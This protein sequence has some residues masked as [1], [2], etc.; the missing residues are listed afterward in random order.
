VPKF[1][2]YM[3]R[4]DLISLTLKSRMGQAEFGSFVDIMSEPS[5]VDTR[6]RQDQERFAQA[7]LSRGIINISYIFNEDLLAPDREIPWR[8][9]I[10]LS[11]MRKDLKMIPVYG[12]M[13]RQDPQQLRKN[14]LWDA[15]RPIRHSDL[16]CAILANSDLA[17]TSENRETQIEDE[18]LIYLRRQYL[19]GTGKIFLR[20][21][22]DLKKLRKQDAL[23]F[24][25]DRLSKKIALRL[26]ET[27]SVE[28]ENLLEE[29]FRNQVIGLDDV[30]PHLKD[31]IL[32]ERMTDKFLN[33]TD[34]FF[35]QLDH[36]KE[37]ENFLTISHSFVRMIPELIRRDHYPEILRILE[38]FKRHFHQK[39]M[40]SLLA[41]QVLEE[42]GRGSI[43]ALLEEKFLT[44][45][46]GGRSAILPI[47]ISLEIGAI[48]HLLSILKKSDDQWVRKNACEVL[49][50]IGPVAAIHLLKALEQQQTSLETTGDILRVLGEIKSEQWKGP[51]SKILSRFVSHNHPRLRAQALQTLCQIEGPGGEEVFLRAMDDPSLEVRKRAVGCLGM[52]KSPLGVERMTEFLEQT[53]SSPQE[54]PLETQ[55]YHA[56][57]ISGNMTIRGRTIEQILL[58]VL[59]KRGMKQWWNPFQKNLLNESS[60]GAI[61]DALG[62]IGTPESLK[63]LIQLAKARDVPWASKAKEACK[64]IEERIPSQP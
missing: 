50:Q 61:C 45:K 64:R 37:K 53:S 3:E 8:A 54:D 1:A 36:A 15:L 27:E 59:Q 34:Q 19:L 31:K 39:M 62:R 58:D 5:L 22:L 41:G 40:W 33:Y 48:P 6:R 63:T 44:A 25:S 35:Q 56:L 57:G 43:P 11:R 55:I 17:A 16:F 47:F 13:L 46:K 7:L 4:K 42:I 12:K 18:I 26:R 60:L 32:V 9:R 51:L 20:E 21:H 14:L 23:E 10:T 52:I 29:Y 24:K 28:T 30:T 38:T 2:K 49:I